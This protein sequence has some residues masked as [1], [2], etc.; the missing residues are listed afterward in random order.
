M[1][2]SGMRCF[3]IARLGAIAAMLLFAPLT[4]SAAGSNTHAPPHSEHGAGGDRH[5]DKFLSMAERHGSPAE[6]PLHCHLQPPHP[7]AIGL[8]PTA[9]DGDLP[10]LTSGYISAPARQAGA[11]L[12][13]I[14]PR[15]PIVG[16]SRF[17]LLG[18]FRS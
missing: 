2:K 6:T 7:Q 14:A 17:I 10:L 1:G 9:I 16:P 11:R 15:I 13:V 4:T 5:V 18:N 3:G 8:A 12:P